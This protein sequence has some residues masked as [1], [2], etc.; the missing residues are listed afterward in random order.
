MTGQSEVSMKLN[1]EPFISV[2]PHIGDPSVKT[3]GRNLVSKTREL[4]LRFLGKRRSLAF[5]LRRTCSR[6]SQL[7]GGDEG[8]V[9]QSTAA[10][11]YELIMCAFK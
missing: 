8:R 9:S 10:G 1:L 3:P 11:A 5:L 2:D 7:L 6:V 4:L